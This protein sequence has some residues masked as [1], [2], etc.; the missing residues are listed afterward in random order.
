MKHRPTI[1]RNKIENEGTLSHQNF[2]WFLYAQRDH[3]MMFH[4]DIFYMDHADRFKHVVLHYTKYSRRLANLILDEKQNDYDHVIVMKKTLIDSFIMTLNLTEIFNV[5]FND[6]EGS[7]HDTQKYLIK[8]QPEMYAHLSEGT[9][10][11][12]IMAFL[13]EYLKICGYLAKVAEELDHLFMEVHRNAVE[14][15]IKKMLVLHLIA[16]DIWNT[17]YWCQ[18]PRRWKEIEEKRIV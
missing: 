16:G 2:H 11:E 10:D 7:L 4:R 1:D 14:E 18:V 15:Q 9:R 3:D 17:E 12:V 6:T 8:K 13:L 5:H